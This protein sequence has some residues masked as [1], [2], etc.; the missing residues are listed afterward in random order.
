[1]PE[2][3]TPRE[4][5][6]VAKTIMRIH[7]QGWGIALGLIFGLGLS[8]AT[9][10]LVVRGDRPLGP[11]LGLLGL[12]FPGYT[13]SYIGALVGFVYAFVLGYGIGRVI[14]TVYNKLTVGM[15]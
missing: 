7:E 2:S 3:L 5:Q 12:Y 13:V 14:A 11:H 9:L 4:R 8:L 6:A 15:R 10:V 1:M